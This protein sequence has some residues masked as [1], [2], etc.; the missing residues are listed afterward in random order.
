MIKNISAL[1]VL[2]A[3]GLISQAQ[4]TEDQNKIKGRFYGGLESN[5]QYYVDDPKL[6]DFEFDDRFRSNNYLNANYNYGKFTA[7]VQVEA[8]EANSLLNYNPKFEGTNLAT[9]YVNYKSDKVDITLGHFYEQFGSGLL[10]RTWEDRALGINNALRGA[11]IV[12][13]PN[14]NIRLTGLYGK[15]RSGFDVTD[16]D[17]YGFDSEF[18]L[19]D[20]LQLEKSDLS[21]GASYVGRYEETNIE[22]PDFSELTSAMAFRFNY[23]LGSFYVN[24]EA[25]YKTEDAVIN[26][27]N[28]ISNDLVKDGSAYQINLGYTKSGLGID[29]T[30]RR[31]ENM[32][33]FSERKPEVIDANNTSINYNDKIMNYVP[34]LTKQHHSNL[35]NIYVFQAQYRVGNL[36]VDILKSGETGGQLDVYYTFKKGTSL[37]GKYGTEIAANFASW[38]NLAGEYRYFPQE[39]DTQF[40]GRGQKYFSDYN[41][42]V[43]KRFSKNWR[44]GFYYVH[45][46][47]DKRLVEGGDQV[48]A[49]IVAVENVISL[50]NKKSLRVELEHMWAD[51]DRRNWAGATVEFN[52]NRNLSV[53]FWDIYNYGTKKEA[54]KNHYFNFGGAYR[55]GATRIALNYG[56]QRGGLVCVGGVCRFVPENTGFT[57]NLSTS[58]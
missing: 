35:A 51:A 11:R 10:L 36:D 57:L 48:N 9:F 58:F 40:F 52:F 53:Y 45:Q 49:D 21:V 20:W 6:G 24:G 32:G 1:V 38:Y 14:H 41:L 5:M 37:G 19:T 26:A 7:G 54:E 3:C 44:T 50:P 27:N 8:Y 30:L 39:Y 23:Y 13:R 46:Y 2:L 28:D 25:N 55:F 43:R 18:Y 16:G 4:E 17:I 56:R 42:E 47:Y 29:L 22:N 15:Q 33:F 34:G 31:L 12:Y